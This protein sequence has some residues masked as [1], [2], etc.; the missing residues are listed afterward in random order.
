MTFSVTSHLTFYLA[1]NSFLKQIST[2]EPDI[3]LKVRH[4]KE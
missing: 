4:A 1:L 2:F 3:M